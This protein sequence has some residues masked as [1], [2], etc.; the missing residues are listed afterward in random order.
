MKSKGVLYLI[1]CASSGADRVPDFV[2]L[3]QEAGWDVCVI[4]TPQ[5]TKFIDMPLLSEMTGH[6]VRSEYKQPEDADVLPRAD[7]LIV[8]PATFNTLNK[9][10]L[11]ITDTLALGILCEYTGLHMPILAVPG[12][13]SASGLDTHP[14]LPRSLRMLK[15]YGVHILYE[16]GDYPNNRIPLDR[17]LHILNNVTE[18]RI[19]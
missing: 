6:P 12:I 15:R 2:K 19:P 5:G 7:A 18:R 17:I 1:S 8:F 16:P 3:A 11:G 10:A 9:W 13:H 4:T 14:A